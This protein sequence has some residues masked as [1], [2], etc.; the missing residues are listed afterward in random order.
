LVINM[1]QP[2]TRTFSL[3]YS[4]GLAE[5]PRA[6]RLLACVHDT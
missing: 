4:Q 5:N 6:N 3:K 2:Q 1:Y